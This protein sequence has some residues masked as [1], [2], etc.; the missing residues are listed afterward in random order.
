MMIVPSAEPT[1]FSLRL[2][3]SFFL[4]THWHMLSPFAVK[5]NTVFVYI[6]LWPVPLDTDVDNN[7]NFQLCIGE[8]WMVMH[9]SY[10]CVCRVVMWKSARRS[11]ERAE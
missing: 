8:I 4:S 11:G 1:L 6:P 2:A 10:S 5:L 3:A 9:W 7:H